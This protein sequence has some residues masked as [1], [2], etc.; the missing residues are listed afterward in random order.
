MT[1]SN[2]PDKIELSMVLPLD[3]LDE[4]DEINIPKDME[5]QLVKLLF[6][7]FVKTLGIPAD[8]TSNS[9]DNP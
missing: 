2:K 1:S 3:N 5:S 8:Q 6:Q 4:D 7:E 9:I